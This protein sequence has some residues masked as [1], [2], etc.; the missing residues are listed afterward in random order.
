MRH[1]G[2]SLTGRVKSH[3]PH[4]D[5]LSDRL[6]EVEWVRA[7]LFHSAAP[8]PAG[9]HVLMSAM[10]GV[11]LRTPKAIAYTADSAIG[12]SVSR[13]STMRSSIAHVG[14]EA[15]SLT[16]AASSMF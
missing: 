15:S 11:S 10:V 9:L 6:E 16:V 13:S 2:N 5:G 8:A 1:R 3:E 4:V 12:S 14:A 7:L